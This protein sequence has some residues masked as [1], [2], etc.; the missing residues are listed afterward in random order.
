MR[1]RS[2]ATLVVLA[3][4]PVLM[5]A[6]GLA[7]QSPPRAGDDTP[8]ASPAAASAEVVIAGRQVLQVAPVGYFTGEDRAIEVMRRIA[9]IL[10]PK[11]DQANLMIA[12]YDTKRDIGVAMVGGETVVQFKGAPVATVTPADAQL[13]GMSVA[14]VAELWARNL[15]T[16]LEGL[17]AGSRTPA[18]PV[19][20]Q[21][22]VVANGKPIADAA[23]GVTETVIADRIRRRIARDPAL[24]GLDLAI[25]VSHD[26]VVLKGDVHDGG[27]QQRIEAAAREEAANRRVRSDLR[28][29]GET[30]QH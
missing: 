28:L 24:R 12:P 19:L 11:N 25:G 13:V 22:T 29:Q 15:Q 20:R 3:C 27:Q 17:D 9:R 5:A 21:I 16:A 10:E 23:T 2:P 6:P 1:T 7:A 18:T 8:A 4:V 26:E 30:G 14:Q